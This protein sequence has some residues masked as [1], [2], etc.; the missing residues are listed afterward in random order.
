[1]KSIHLISFTNEL[2]VMAIDIMSET[3][4]RDPVPSKCYEWMA[5]PCDSTKNI[6]ALS[7]WK[8]WQDATWAEIEEK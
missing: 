1:M 8:I 6:T 2:L 5:K 7:G 4:R 3:P